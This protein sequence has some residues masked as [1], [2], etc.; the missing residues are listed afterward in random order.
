MNM[1]RGFLRGRIP[2]LVDELLLG[3]LPICG[4]VSIWGFE[5]EISQASFDLYFGT[6][7]GGDLG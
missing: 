3:L 5:V 6:V 2:A 4:F 1:R 7:T